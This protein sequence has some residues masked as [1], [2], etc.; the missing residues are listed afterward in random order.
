[1]S[2]AI[3]TLSSSVMLGYDESGVLDDQ[4]QDS[5]NPP[6]LRFGGFSWEEYLWSIS[7]SSFED[8]N[9]ISE[10]PKNQNFLLDLQRKIPN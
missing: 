6:A 10:N 3:W 2:P 1:M 9:S 4:A 7:C 8:K 5:K